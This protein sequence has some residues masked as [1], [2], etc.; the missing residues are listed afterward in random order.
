M[1]KKTKEIYDYIKVYMLSTGFCPSQREIMDAMGWYSLSSVN[2]H[3]K[4][5]EDAGLLIRKTETS[6][7]YKLAGIKYVEVDYGK[8]E[9]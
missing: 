7:I 2:N 4:K 9:P 6:P 1:T 3:I 5:L 8:N